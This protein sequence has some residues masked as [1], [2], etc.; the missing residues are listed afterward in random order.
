MRLSIAICRCQHT[1]FKNQ[2]TCW[3]QTLA[4][5]ECTKPGSALVFVTYKRGCPS[6]DRIKDI[7]LFYT[8]NVMGFVMFSFG[9]ITLCGV[10]SCQFPIVS[11]KRLS[12]KQRLTGWSPSRSSGLLVA[13]P[14]LCSPY[15]A[16]HSLSAIEQQLLC[17]I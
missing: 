3:Q 14:L 6:L 11:N 7:Y 8:S 10:C 12:S 2:N 16:H 15:F 5:G 1:V 13:A 17:L 4:T 9:V